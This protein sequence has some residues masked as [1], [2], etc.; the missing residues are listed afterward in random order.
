MRQYTL[1]HVGPLFC[2]FLSIN[3]IQYK[4]SDHTD[5]TFVWLNDATELFDLGAKF[6]AYKNSLEKPKE[7]IFLF[8]R[9]G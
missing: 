3:R 9:I 7:K 2:H 6:E 5:H 1:R 4:Q 8:N